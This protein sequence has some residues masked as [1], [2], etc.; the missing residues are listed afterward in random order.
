MKFASDRLYLILAISILCTANLFAQ[1]DSLVSG[2]FRNANFTEFAQQIESSTNYHFYFDTAQTNGFSVSI[3]VDKQPLSGILRQLFDKTEFLFS[4]DDDMNVFVT[5]KIKILTQLP[6]GFFELGQNADSLTDAKSLVNLNTG[7]AEDDK[8]KTAVENK[9][10]V[11]GIR[12]SNTGKGNA[13]IAGYVRDIKSGEPLIG[14]TVYVDNP[15][16]S[17]VTDQ[18]GYYSL[19]LPKGRHVIK[20]SSEGMRDTKRQVML[21]AD[22]K[23]NVNMQDYVQSLKSVIV[24]SEKKSNVK[25]LQ[26]G[27]ERLNMQVIKQI[28]VVFG[29]VDVLR[30][31]LTLPGVTSAG[32]ASTGFNVRGGSSN[33]NLIL[34]DGATIYNPSHLFGFFSAFN[35]DVIKDVELYKSSIPEKYGGRISSV[36]DITS[37]EGNNKKFSGEG[38]VGPLTGRLTLEGPIVKDKTSF[39][40]GARAT[41]SDW[42]LRTLKNTDY[43]NSS[44]SFYDVNL[45][46]N[47]EI[48]AKNKL[49]LTGYLSHDQ[50]R[51]NS[52][53]LYKYS[54]KDI[55]LKWKHIFNNKLN[56]LITLGYDRYEYSITGAANTENGYNLAFDINQTNFKADFT[57]TASAV[58]SID[59]GLSTIYYK[60]HPGSYEPVGNQSLV[61]PNVVQQE[62]A[63]ETA[64]YLGDKYEIS[65]K[66]SLQG[67]VRFSI[68]NYLGPHDVYTYAS[69]MPRDESSL[70]DTIHYKKDAFIKT[71]A[72]P[73]FRFA[74]RYALSDNSSLKVSYNS[75]RQFIHLLTET[76]SISP[77]DI[78]KLSDQYIQPQIGNQYSVG[79]YKNLKSGTIETS[80]EVYYK[81]LQHY[82]DYKNGAMLVLNHHIETD[83]VN[84]IGKSS[85]IELMIKKLTGKLNGWISYTFSRTFL[86]QDD[87]L[88][89]QPINNGSYYP[90]DFDKPHSVNFIGNYRVSHRV[91]CVA[92][93]CL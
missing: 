12:A 32:E 76:T 40:I 16:M 80:V 82:L 6:R 64:V 65:P 81:T 22:G 24:S 77:T 72:A 3:N 44:A 79:F 5:M 93:Y 45:E 62:Q 92:R 8:L 86:K 68:Y 75:L 84:T 69:G 35:P 47:H 57:Y 56:S 19:T 41:Y 27:V 90:A 70:E 48:N 4:I 21:Y 17:S 1:R 2:N 39:L 61:V 30:S 10:F 33:Q 52:D 11:I 28:P 15:P 7:E 26:M 25:S 49:F 14:A 23:L 74:A 63:N 29:E 73:E 13:T 60:L 18:F 37:R 87:P 55:N 67:G 83:V 36:L 38:G 31:V 9:L 46:V 89:G 51:L 58:H 20:I 53:T 59:F 85:G 34:F 54:S 50:F 42:L 66:L 43:S 78:W 71:Y 91:Q 88:A